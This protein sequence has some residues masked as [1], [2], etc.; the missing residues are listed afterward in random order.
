MGLTPFITTLTGIMKMKFLGFTVGILMFLSLLVI[1]DFITGIIAS[2]AEGK[3]LTSSRGLRSVHKSIS[4]FMFLC[5]V[6]LFQ[7]QL[8]E[9]GHSLGIFFISQIRMLIFLQISLWEWHS[10][11]ENYERR[12]GYKPKIFK[13][14]D[15]LGE[16]LEKR[17]AKKMEDSTLCPTLNTKEDKNKKSSD[18]LDDI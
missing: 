8:E 18:K 1:L 14:L 7:G 15:K 4:Y 9:N 5:F 16:L 2:K 10:I 6:S 11:G 12:F 3:T 17:I 13:L